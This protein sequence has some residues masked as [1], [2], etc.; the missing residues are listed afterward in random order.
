M[1]W[2]VT[3]G[4]TNT[5]EL[6][7][8]DVEAQVERSETEKEFGFS[9]MLIVTGHFRSDSAL[10]T[11]RH[12]EAVRQRGEVDWDHAKWHR[13]PSGIPLVVDEVSPRR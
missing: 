2:Q 5:C 1:L 6:W 7:N 8:V 13:W 11:L 10:K 4:T 3:C 12:G 9:A